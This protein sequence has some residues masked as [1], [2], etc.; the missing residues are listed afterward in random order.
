[1]RLTGTWQ[2][3]ISPAS[4]SSF[5]FPLARRHA[6]AKSSYREGCQPLLIE[7]RRSNSSW[8]RA[9]ISIVFRPVVPWSAVGFIEYCERVEE[10]VEIKSSSRSERSPGDHARRTALA[11]PRRDV[12]ARLQLQG[13]SDIGRPTLRGCFR[14]Q[15]LADRLASHAMPAVTSKSFTSRSA[16][17]RPRRTARDGPTVDRDREPSEYLCFDVGDSTDL[18][19]PFELSGCVVP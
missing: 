12:D 1:M 18:D 11:R 5:D 7:V 3:S 19:A 13:L 15:G 2:R 6:I 17:R 9:R 16:Y 8:P 14:P 4:T 10:P